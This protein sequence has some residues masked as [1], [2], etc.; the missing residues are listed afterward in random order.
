MSNKITLLEYNN[1]MML[2]DVRLKEL[3]NERPEL[4]RKDF[5]KEINISYTTVSGWLN[6]GKEPIYDNL[7]TVA[8]YFNVTTDYLLG[9]TDS[10]DVVFGTNDV[11]TVTDNCREL[12]SICN[13]LG[14][15]KLAD[16]TKYARY[17]RD[18]K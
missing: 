8:K 2:F 1:S 7:V 5:A 12:I 3:L 14:K 17:L 16:V 11:M 15:E 9:L 4:S 18:Q 6:D 13:V 10:I